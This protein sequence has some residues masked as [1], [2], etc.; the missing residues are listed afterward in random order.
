MRHLKI[1]LLNPPPVTGERFIRE[2]RCM[3]NVDSWATV[4]PPM[5]LTV[6]ASIAR[7]HG[8]VDLF[9]GNVEDADF[10]LAAAA[11]RCA[12]FGPDVVVVNTAFGSIQGD[13]ATAAAIKQACPDALIVGYGLFFTL[14][15]EASMDE[16][17]PFDVGI[18]GE[19]EGTFEELLV[20]MKAGTPLPGMDGLMW[21]EGGAV[22]R[23]GQRPWIEPLDTLPV[24]ARDLLRNDRYLMPHTGR[25]FALVNVARGCPYPCNYCIAPVYYG[26]THR[27]HSIAYL[28][29]ELE[30]CQQ[31]LG[32]RDFLFWE[33]V[34][35]FDRAFGMGLARAII[36]R[37][38]EIE[39]VST[40]RADCLD[41]EMLDVM[42]RSGCTLMGL[43][44][45]SVHQHILDAAE[46]Q[47]KVEDIRRAVKLLKKAGIK[48][49]GHF[50]FGLPGETPET[51]E[52]TIRAQQEMGFDYVQSYAAVPWPK[53]KFGELARE[54]GWITSFNWTDYDTGGRSIVDMG[55]LRPEQVDDA[56]TSMYRRFYLRP[57]FVA[58][59]VGELLRNPRQLA[60]ASRFFN[61]M[62]HKDERD[63]TLSRRGE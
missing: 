14:L 5:S 11:R 9:D 3:Q 41:E 10:D 33:E 2:G 12:A 20:R 49:M 37:G 50:V 32:I 60:Q 59:Q 38:W 43:G 61:W 27:V 19:P 6:L 25:P 34:M 15:D 44:V 57:G 35:T 22:R 18:H 54:R 21:R 23:G 39:W 63:L 45:E 47:L 36:D 16:V 48:S 4:W 55:T 30:Q 52:A 46:K 8:E 58:R 62:R 28:M 17:P 24:G 7:R 40:T 31:E 51:I 29:D 53:T 1:T 13:A 56:R 42:A 26:K